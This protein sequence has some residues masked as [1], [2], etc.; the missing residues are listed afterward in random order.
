MFALQFVSKTLPEENNIEYQAESSWSRCHRALIT[1]QNTR[2]RV[3]HNPGQRFGTNGESR[4]DCR[5]IG[6]GRTPHSISTDVCDRRKTR[7]R[8]EPLPN[9]GFHCVCSDRS[10]G[11][12][13]D[14][15]LELPSEWMVG[16]RQP[17]RQVSVYLACYNKYRNK[18]LEVTQI[19]F[20]REKRSVKL[21]WGTS[22][23][24]GWKWFW[25][26]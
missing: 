3:T 8:H 14:T 2:K 25:R 12:M 7:T 1:Y 11:Q 19:F 10:P 23:L 20:I 16:L 6:H 4:Q 17:T 21:R 5:N 22:V 15:K 13:G 9:F 24:F 18:G 26:D